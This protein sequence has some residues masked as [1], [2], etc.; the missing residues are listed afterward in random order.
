MKNLVIRLNC[1]L[2]C[3]LSVHMLFA[4]APSGKNVRGTVI[5]KNDKQPIIG[6]TVTLLD[7]DGRTVRGTTTDIEGNYSLP[8]PNPAFR[9]A[10]SYLGYK[11]TEP[12]V[13]GEKTLINFQLVSSSKDLDQVIITARKK[14]DDGSGLLVDD[15]DRTVSSFK[16]DAKDMEEMQSA[17]IDQALQGRMPGV[18]IAAISGDPGAPMQI[19]IRGVSS[20]NGAVDPLIIVDGMPFE[21]TIPDDFNFATSDE[22]GYGQLLNIAP[23]D[24]KDIT[25]LKDAAAT[26]IYGSRA[27][28]GVLVINTKRGTVGKPQLSYTVKGS[29]GKQPSQ[30]PT[31]NGNQYSTLI[32]EEFYNS[33]IQFST[34]ESA[35]QF[36]YD[37]NDPYNFYNF[38]NNTNWIESITQLGYFHDHSFSINGGGQKA[39]YQASVNYFNQEGTTKG[40]AFARITSRVNLDYI[41]S[42]KIQ[43][44]ADFS[45]TRGDNDQLYLGNIRNTAYIKMPNQAIYEYDEYGNQSDNYFSPA[46]TAQGRYDGSK[47]GSV[48]NPLA[49]AEVGVSNRIDQRIMPK[50]QLRYNITPVL[51]FTGDMQIDISNS[52]LKTFL[53]Q[54]ATG[55]PFTNPN[56]NLAGDG[57]SDGFGVQTRS[58]LIYNPQLGD[59]HW[60]Q[61]MVSFQTSDT[62]RTGQSL[63]GTNTASSFLQ[64]PVNPSRTNGANFAGAG[65]GQTRT[66]GLVFQGMYKFMDKYII[67]TSLRGDGSSRFGP[68]N[69]FGV[70]PGASLAWRINQENFLKNVKKINDLKL[71]LSYAQIGN[72][73]RNDYTFYN[74]YQSY[75]FSYLGQTGIISNDMELT[76]LQWETKSSYNVGLDLT[77]L[78]NRLELSGEVYQD[79]ITNMFYN[80]LQIPSYNGYSTVDL[81]AGTMRNEGWEFFVRGNPVKNKKIRVDA[82]FNIAFNQN[83]ITSISRLYPRESDA[84]KALENGKFKTYFQENNPFGSF[85]GFRYKGIYQN[86]DATVARDRNG[87]KIVSPDGNDVYMK[88]GA[89][90]S[91]SYQFQ[92]GDTMYEDINHDGLIDYKD[93]VYLGN[94]NPKFNGGFGGTITYKGNL[95]L[96]AAF[97]FRQGNDLI[98]G[99]KITSTS[100][101]NFNNQSTAVLRRWRKEGDQTDIPRALFGKGYNFLGSDKYVEDGSFLRLRSVTARY[102]FGKKLVSKI[103]VKSLGAYLTAENLLTFTRYTGQ[104]PEVGI[105]IGGPFSVVQDNSTTP[106][107]KVFT[108]GLTT[109]F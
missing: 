34:N 21:T 79:R 88:I 77:M 47:A 37:R 74:T 85:Y 78:N 100:M 73:P 67:S 72:A 96:S 6:A 57:D 83:L 92:P 65:A 5:D 76:N 99:T 93:I 102:D 17:S 71:R 60:G 45:Y 26:A 87:N 10:V 91:V 68:G 54:I 58:N 106:P 16:V 70:F 103:G 55:L 35:K 43:F 12:I 38:S 108:F 3:V 32:L 8:V 44:R 1:L 40:T 39:K 51:N 33:G 95:K 19:R 104:D 49:M 42:S 30:I 53:P 36:Q 63:T 41:V 62:R 27:A 18:D 84:G 48:Y 81:N 82:S 2:I 13:V 7:R 24:I 23:A 109:R 105:R 46:V 98:N 28:N 56:V 59:K 29:F 15:R 94:G 14:S 107:T 97:N 50:F 90:P 52:K 4:Q 75:G 64:D 22:N 80:D 66:L 25:V 61:A 89:G 101:H 86:L 31:L 11:S 20:I 9:L 69:R